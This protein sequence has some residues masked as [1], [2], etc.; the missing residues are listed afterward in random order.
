M[1]RSLGVIA[2]VIV[3]FGTV[4]PATAGD[5]RLPKRCEGAG[6]APESDGR[7]RTPVLLVH[8]FFGEPGNFRR[9]LLTRADDGQPSMLESIAALDGVT[10]Y[11]F[12]YSAT[13]DE[14]V[15]NQAIGPA[16]AQSI[17]CLAES[18]G[19]KVMVV[20]HSMGGLA[21]RLAQ[22]EVIDGRA[23][24]DSLSRAV[25]IGTPSR[26][27]LLLTYANDRLSAFVIQTVINGAGEACSD[28]PKKSDRLL[29]ELLDAANAPATAAM[30]PGSGQLG[31]LPA[32]GADVVVHPIA[33]DLQ[34]RLSVFGVGT[35]ESI[36]D[37]VATVGS[38][39]ADESP[40]EESFVVECGT[41]LTEIVDDVDE[42]PC[43]HGNLVANRRIIRDM[44]KQVKLAVRQATKRSSS[45]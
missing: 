14:W 10:V 9:E 8:G 27:V 16:L 22:G 33:G 30:A 21:T 29:C 19:R 39:T 1:R 25:I 17:V 45:R 18:S 26:G 5:G 40:G 3:L 34:V 37:L 42:S 36:G 4:A 31:A 12:D 43:S 23:V 15:T 11:M 6:R 32:W 41:E 44:V 28:K 38:A 7:G 13:S 20:A 24:S 2:C 35:T